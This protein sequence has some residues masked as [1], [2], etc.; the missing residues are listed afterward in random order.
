MEATENSE[1]G[2]PLAVPL[3]DLLGQPA[4]TYRSSLERYAV[5]DD[6]GL[7]K[8]RNPFSWETLA[9]VAID[10][11]N[12]ALAS[13][14]ERLRVMLMAHRDRTVMSCYSSVRECEAARNALQR[15]L[16]ELA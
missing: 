8:P 4:P 5:F 7:L 13:K 12:A 11:G 2:Q 9:R 3:S 6:E 14:H 1:Q 10:L 16:D 15:V